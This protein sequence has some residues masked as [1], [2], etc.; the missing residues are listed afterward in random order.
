MAPTW[1]HAGHV[2]VRVWEEKEHEE[3]VGLHEG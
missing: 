1:M 3:W 2:C